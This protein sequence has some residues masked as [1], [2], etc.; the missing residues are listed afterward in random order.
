MY[1]DNKIIPSTLNP[2]VEGEKFQKIPKVIYQ[3][4][5]SNIVSDKIYEGIESY[6]SLNPDYRYEFYDDDRMCS[7]I[8]SYNCS[9]FNFNLEE[10]KKAFYNIVPPAGKADIWRYLIIYENGGIYTDI[11]SKC[12]KPFSS[13]I[14]PDDD[15]VT[16]LTGIAH[17]YDNPTVVWR[18]LF[19]QWF[20]IYS[21][22]C[23]ILKEIIEECVKAVNTKIPVPNSEDCKNM[24]ER[25]TGV[26]L[27]NYVYRKLFNFKDKDKEARLQPRVYS[28]KHSKNKYNLAIHDSLPDI[29]NTALISKNFERFE[30]YKKELLTNNSNHWLSYDSIFKS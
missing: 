14:N 27:S 2:R 6:I 8:D 10:L 25:Y 30:D 13:Y 26:C 20:L 5:K 17:N 24:L 1:T 23:S 7:Y 15:I 4:F 11:D 18:H 22:K 21:P 12:I 19:P 16:C 28:I 9:D 3:T 29:F